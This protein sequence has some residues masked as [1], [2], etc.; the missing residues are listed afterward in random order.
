M[1]TMKL[2]ERLAGVAPIEG[3]S[4]G[5]L[6]DKQ[7]WKVEFANAATQNHR[8]A[9]KAVIDGWTDADWEG[10]PAERRSGRLE[11][12]VGLHQRILALQREQ[13]QNPTQAAQ[14]QAKVDEAQAQIEELR[15]QG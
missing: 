8:N 9:A 4:I 11:R 13:S 6:E 3:V 14:L 15:R 12:I 7:T 5:T 10:T 2:H 1:K